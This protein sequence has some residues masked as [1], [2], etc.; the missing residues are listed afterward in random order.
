[1]SGGNQIVAGETTL[2]L[3]SDL[4]SRPVDCHDTFQ[5]CL[6]L[7][8][9]PQLNTGVAGSENNFWVLLDFE[10][11]VLHAAIT[12]AE[13]TVAALGIDNDGAACFA[14]AEIASDSSVLK[15]EN[16]VRSMERGRQAKLNQCF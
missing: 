16:S 10:N 2:N 14:C 1:M 8:V 9:F 15:F 11:A 12:Q 3:E 6:K 4:V 13:A 5:F 7:T